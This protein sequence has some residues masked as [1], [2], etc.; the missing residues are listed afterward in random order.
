MKIPLTIAKGETVIMTDAGI[1]YGKISG[2]NRDAET[3]IHY[4]VISHNEVT[5]AFYDTA[6]PV[7]YVCCPHCGGELRKKF[8]AKRCP[9]CYKKLDESDF[10]DTEPESYVI[11]DGEYQASLSTDSYDIFI[12]KSPYYSLSSFCSPCAPGAG[13]LLSNNPDGV[14]TYCFGHDF[15]ESGIAPYA[16]YSVKTG[17][18]IFPEKKLSNM[19]KKRFK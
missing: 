19:Y 2:V 13:F 10:Y 8:E 12:I 3:G 5:Q 9:H 4:G 17:E 15:F 6:E 14:K 16:V 1:D 7:Y 18:K 11:N